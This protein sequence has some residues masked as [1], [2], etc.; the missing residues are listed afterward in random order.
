M[1]HFF[2]FL[3]TCL[4][5]YES[6][7]QQKFYI[8]SNGVLNMAYSGEKQNSYIFMVDKSFDQKKFD[9]ITGGIPAN[10]NNNILG[11]HFQKDADESEYF[12]VFING[13]HEIVGC[14]DC[15]HVT[16]D[17]SVKINGV[18]LG[19]FHLTPVSQVDVDPIIP[20]N[21]IYTPGSII[22]D[23]IY[24]AANMKT[25]SKAPTIKN[26]LTTQYSITNTADLNKNE[27]LKNDLQYVFTSG[28]VQGALNLKG[29]A[30]AVG[31]IDVTTIADGFAKFIVKRTKQELSIA[32]F[33]KFKKEI[34]SNNDLKMLFP[35]THAL[36]LIIDSEIYRYSN[37]INNLREAFRAD[38]NIIDESL[39]AIVD[40]HPAFFAKD[41]NFILKA[42]LLSGC[43]ISTSLRQDE[44]PGDILQGFPLSYLDKPP[45][46]EKE[47]IDLLKGGIQTLQLFSES[48]KET[49]TVKK[50]YWVGIDKIREVAENPDVT[51]IY[52]GLLIEVAKKKYDK[53]AYASNKNLYDLLNQ[54]STITNF[55][56]EYPKYK[57]F[58]ISIGTKTSELNKMIKGFDKAS[59]DSLKVEQYAKYF[60]TT[61][62]LLECVSDIS[63]LSFLNSIS[64]I[65]TFSK[66][67][68][69][70][71]STAYQ[72]TDLVTA[73]NRKRYPEVVNQTV[74]I[75]SSVYAR[76]ATAQVPAN[77]VTLSKKEK[78]E[79][80]EAVIKANADQKVAQVIAAN[81]PVAD[82]INDKDT[83]AKEADQ[84]LLMITRYGA[85]MA[86][87]VEAKNS[88]E[89]EAAIE[90]VALPVGSSSIKRETKFNV[91][92]N[93][94]CGL[95]VGNEIIKG[96]DENKPFK[97]F[98][99][100][101][102]TAPIG[103]SISRGDHV[104]FIFPGKGWSSSLFL[105]IVDLGAIASYRFND[106][107]TEQVPEIKLED[108]LSPGIFLSLGIPKTPISFNFGTQ[109]GPN[110]RKV[111]SDANDY[112]G[113]LYV[114]YSLS[115]C[116]DI[117]LLNLYTKSKN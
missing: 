104:F 68:K 29:I 56:A 53:V 72:F 87:M 100:F 49:D 111:N 33:Q 39:P 25:R 89:V 70:Y 4:T 18:S 117:P 94:Y 91:S 43:Y 30:N 1:K 103:I 107:K 14:D 97:K 76:P 69:P 64:G 15:K 115:F 90:S 34:D 50:A 114:R 46:V 86:S 85:F 27:F 67:T 80:A 19:T 78:I 95:F 55:T 17:F 74:F 42:S 35:K 65:Q 81:K 102:V 20:S 37:Y 5:I 31:G 79:F 63:S 98:N 52:L 41:Q 48:F 99:S 38:L 109:I 13:Q 51:K 23:A 110:L 84:V 26:L 105:S 73:I 71:F 45:A 66:E 96:V 7:A 83:E 113:K 16:D 28:N 54:S 57:K 93:A 12:K 11:N 75:Y 24:I 36:L 61:V 58:I 21:A 112:S 9:I 22:N 2:I 88:D 10:N 116:V 106:D 101:G 62:Q 47:K 108:I 82:A 8:N 77:I 60:K 44:H 40:N 32:F 92:L 3:L 6:Y 59:S